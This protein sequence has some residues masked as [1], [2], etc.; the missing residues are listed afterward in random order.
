[1]DILGGNTLYVQKKVLRSW[2]LEVVGS[3]GLEDLR[4][5]NIKETEGT[6]APALFHSLPSETLVGRSGGRGPTRVSEG[7]WAGG[8][9]GISKVLPRRRRR[10]PPA[11]RSGRARTRCD[12]TDERLGSAVTSRA[13]VAA[14]ADRRRAGDRFGYG[15]GN[16]NGY[17]NG[18]GRIG[19]PGSAALG[20]RLEAS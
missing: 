19:R 17:G 12:G 15:N 1:M 14:I 3:W 16:G 5:P 6:P 2:G 18:N 13:A 8:G 4:I 11:R 9:G 20:S 10:G 7:G